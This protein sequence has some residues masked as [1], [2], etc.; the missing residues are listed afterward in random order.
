MPSSPPGIHLLTTPYRLSNQLS[1]PA[2]MLDEDASA[3]TLDGTQGIG[4][5][6]EAMGKEWAS[7]SGPLELP[8]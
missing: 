4:G 1:K 6:E 3:D 2:T 7:K 5:A 8:W